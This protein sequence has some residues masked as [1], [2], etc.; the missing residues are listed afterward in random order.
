VLSW[1]STLVRLALAAVFIIAG[2][3]KVA[4]PQ[5]SV[6]GVHAYQIVPSA[7][8]AA[9]GWGLPFAEIALGLL[10]VSGLFTRGL[11]I[12]AAVVLVSFMAAVVSAWARGLSIDCGC[13]GGGGRVAPGQAHY[14]EE[15]VRDTWFCLLAVWL[16][17]CPRSRLSLDR[18]WSADVDEPAGTLGGGR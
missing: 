1:V 11:A 15:L 4:D 2:G 18:T 7:L 10:L 12:V 9:V 8:E 16:V 5:A 3:L 17:I 6:Q 13:F 14:V